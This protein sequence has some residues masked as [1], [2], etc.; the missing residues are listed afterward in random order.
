[1]LPNL[2]AGLILSTFLNL[3]G[4]IAPKEHIL[5]SHQLSLED[6]QPDR[7]VNGV[8][9]DNI[10][11]N[12]SY[13][14]G[15]TKYSS[16]DW[17]EVRKPFHYQFELAPGQVFAFHDTLLPQYQGKVTKTTNAHFNSQEGFESDGY[18]VGDGVCHLASLIYWVAR[19]ANLEAVAPTNHNFAA[20]EDI[21]R[22]YGVAIYNYPGQNDTSAKQNLYITNNLSNPVVFKFDYDGT[23]L[24]VSILEEI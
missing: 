5:A 20:I 13:M 15:K 4:T 9:K 24:Q 8:F 3:Q 12:L 16:V 10:L 14:E 6:R 1:M 19:D 11:L 18:L 23:K 22:E 7:F 17:N 2:V 21:S